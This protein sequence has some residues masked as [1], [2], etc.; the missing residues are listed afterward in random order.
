MWRPIQTYL[1]NLFVS[2][3]IFG[4]SAL[5]DTVRADKILTELIDEQKI[6]GLSITVLKDAKTLFQKGYGYANLE[7]DKLVNPENT[8]GAENMGRI[9]LT[10]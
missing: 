2:K 9:N 8:I 10:R 4:N 7:N 5:G 1:K 6:P 3:R